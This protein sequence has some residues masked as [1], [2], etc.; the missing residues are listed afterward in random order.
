MGSGEPI[1]TNNFGV[2]WP[3]HPREL[4]IEQS[5]TETSSKGIA[6]ENLAGVIHNGLGHD[7]HWSGN[8]DLGRWSGCEILKHGGWV[9]RKRV[10]EE[11]PVLG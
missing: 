5:R 6:R 10:S 4:S 11:Q 7:R 8:P 2:G 3:H 1:C 9:P